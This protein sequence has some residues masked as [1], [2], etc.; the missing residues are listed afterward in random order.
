MFRDIHRL[1]HF[2]GDARESE[3]GETQV[4]SDQEEE[5]T[6]RQSVT[7]ESKAVMEKL[8][9][10][11]PHKFL[12]ENISNVYFTMFLRFQLNVKEKIWP[13]NPCKHSH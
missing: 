7:A 11:F 6:T 1:S 2:R 8:C 3:E 4:G 12:S 9:S 10:L 13:V 5:D